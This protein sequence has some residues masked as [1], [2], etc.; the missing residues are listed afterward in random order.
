VTSNEILD[1]ERRCR[2]EKR[3]RRLRRREQVREDAIARVA[4]SGRS[5]LLRLPEVEAIVGRRKSSICADP[6]FPK[7]VVTGPRTVGWIADEVYAWLEARITARD[8][9]TA[10]RSLPLDE[11]RWTCS[12][13]NSSLVT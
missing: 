10:R 8:D 2:D 11:L 3:D 13:L 4:A 1:R 5:R 9:N 12:T 6:D 7:R